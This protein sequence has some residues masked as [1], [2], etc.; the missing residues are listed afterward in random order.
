MEIQGSGG[1]SATAPDAGPSPSRPRARE[2]LLLRGRGKYM[3]HPP[4]RKDAKKTSP[5]SRRVA[6]VVPRNPDS[7]APQRATTRQH[8]APSNCT[9]QPSL[10]SCG[11]HTL[12]RRGSEEWGEGAWW[13]GPLFRPLRSRE[14][15]KEM[16]R[17]RGK[18]KKASSN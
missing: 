12:R 7:S 13:H 14:R 9:A 3:E 8:R 1:A 16:G 5:S 11:K 15:K 4:R 6:V 18:G 10:A 2:S 17:V